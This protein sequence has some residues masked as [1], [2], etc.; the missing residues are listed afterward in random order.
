MMKSVIFGH[1]ELSCTYFF[2]GLLPFMEK[3]SLKSKIK[4]LV[5]NIHYVI[6][7]IILEGKIWSHVDQLAIDLIQKMLTYNPEERISAKEALTHKYF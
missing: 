2:V 6:K 3:M 7:L 5:E 4:F 1:V